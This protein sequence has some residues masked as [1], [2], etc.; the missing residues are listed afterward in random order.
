MADFFSDFT[1]D[2]IVRSLDA[3]AMNHLLLTNNIANVN[4][5]GYQRME[6]SFKQQLKDFLEN[7]KFKAERTNPN[8]IPIGALTSLDEVQP[9][10]VVDDDTVMRADQNNVDIDKEMAKLAGNSGQYAGLSQLLSY[11]FKLLNAAI[12]G[13]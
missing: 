9:K 8:H 6:V 5:P 11:K 4:T 2:I 12:M 3:D 1:M 10:I 13:Q 7:K